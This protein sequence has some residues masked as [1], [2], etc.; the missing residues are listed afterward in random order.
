MMCS[1]EGLLEG[2]G[3]SLLENNY[4]IT[5]PTIGLHCKPTMSSWF[6]KKRVPKIGISCASKLILLL[7]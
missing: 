7:A 3:R 4:I 5:D 2:H 6:E 1:L